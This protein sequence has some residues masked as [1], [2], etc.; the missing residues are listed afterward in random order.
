MIK[1]INNNN[2][3]GVL[4]YIKSSDIDKVKEGFFIQTW[5]TIVPETF[6]HG[7]WLGIIVDT[8]YY[9]KLKDQKDTLSS[10]TK[11]LIL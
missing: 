7:G 10:M 8:S 5:Y 6:T 1:P 2:I 4:I 3:K 9:E 11:D